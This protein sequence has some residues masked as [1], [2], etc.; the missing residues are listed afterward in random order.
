MVK[1]DDIHSSFK[2]A[3]F[4]GN[5]FFKSFKLKLLII[6]LPNIFGE[7]PTIEWLIDKNKC[8][9][10][11]DLKLCFFHFKDKMMHTHKGN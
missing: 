3:C 5:L 8:D 2:N 4:K 7:T 11:S 6:Q 1:P 9:S 10:L